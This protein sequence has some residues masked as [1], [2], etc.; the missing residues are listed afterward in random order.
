MFSAASNL[1]AG[2]LLNIW[3]AGFSV[4][5]SGLLGLV[6][7]NMKRFVTAIDANTRAV[8]EI[9]VDVAKNYISKSDFYAIYERRKEPR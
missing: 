3:I 6:L 8:E 5:A 4:L 7:W 1:L 9:R 2:E